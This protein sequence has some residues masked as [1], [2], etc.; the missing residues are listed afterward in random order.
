MKYAKRAD[1]ARSE[2]QQPQTPRASAKG[3]R[4]RFILPMIRLSELARLARWRAG[5]SH[6]VNAAA[7]MT[8]AAH[9]IADLSGMRLRNK[10]RHPG[11]D[12]VTATD[13]LRNAGQ[14]MEEDDIMHIVH[15]VEDGRN[16]RDPFRM[17]PPLAGQITALTQTE[18]TGLGIV[19]ME[20]SDETAATRKARKADEKRD[21]DRERQ[22][23]KRRS[24][25]FRIGPSLESK[26]PWKELGI[27][28]ATYFRRK[29]SETLSHRETASSRTYIKNVER[30]FSLTHQTRD[31]AGAAEGQALAAYFGSG[32][33]IDLDRYRARRHANLLQAVAK[34]LRGDAR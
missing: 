13:F 33:A 1:F 3:F 30:H 20:A 25:R 12:F 22:R 18:R 6:P 27:G 15:A 11:L 17:K 5:A 24:A 28:R 2:N 21:A 34:S 23:E 32:V 8:V 9:A 26:A 29:K 14:T 10:G 4:R 16:C 19:T 31:I 7:F